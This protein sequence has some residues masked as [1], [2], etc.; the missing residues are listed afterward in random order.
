MVDVIRRFKL[1]YSVYNF[2][3]RKEL[4]H[5][6][7]VYKKLGINKKY[8]SPVSSRDFAAFENGHSIVIYPGQIK[9]TPLFHSLNSNSRQSLLG[10][11][12]NGFAILENFLTPGKV[13]A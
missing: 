10:F 7:D 13:D 2:F 3:H 9:A 1:A 12:T 4:R 5:N 11:D 6:E 8:Y